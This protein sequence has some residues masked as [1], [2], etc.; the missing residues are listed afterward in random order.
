MNIKKNK[1]LETEAAKDADVLV[2]DDC[3]FN[4][5]AINGLLQQ[6]NYKSH[7]S[8]NGKE[9]IQAIQTRVASGKPMYKLIMMDYSMP[10]C[11]GPTAS[12]AIR[13]FLTENGYQ[14]DQ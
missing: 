3:Q 13:N 7:Y 4:F 8:L 2:V 11:D 6:F 5:I 10:V 1:L 12:N 14:R 9:A